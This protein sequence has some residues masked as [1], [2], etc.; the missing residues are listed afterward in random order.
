MN[1]KGFILSDIVLIILIGLSLYFGS[2]MPNSYYV[3]AINILAF[4]TSLVP[5]LFV[6]T[7]EEDYQPF[8]SVITSTVSCLTFITLLIN[9]FSLF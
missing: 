7:S 3:L 4:I 5:T 1:N 8:I 2:I 6:F 9:I